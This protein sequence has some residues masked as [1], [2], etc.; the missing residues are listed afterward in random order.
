[1][2][3]HKMGNI[4]QPTFYVKLAP[5]FFDAKVIT[6]IIFPEKPGG[7]PMQVTDFKI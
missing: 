5:E 2:K 7:G 6:C 1:M 3:M 4:W